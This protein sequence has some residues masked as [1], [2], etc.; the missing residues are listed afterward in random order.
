VLIQPNKKLIFE[1]GSICLLPVPSQIVLF[2]P[3]R[4]KI[5]DKL[6]RLKAKHMQQHGKYIELTQVLIRTSKQ[7]KKI[8]AYISQY[9]HKLKAGL[10][11]QCGMTRIHT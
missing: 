9:K 8:Q 7:M 4:L 3:G 2:F 6:S 5:S 11:L 1:V 10:T